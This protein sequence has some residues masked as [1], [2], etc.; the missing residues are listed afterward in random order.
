LEI[1]ANLNKKKIIITTLLIIS[2]PLIG[3]LLKILFYAARIYG[4][5]VRILV[6]EGIC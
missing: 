4:S 3:Y 5:Y 6:E 1:Y 2:M